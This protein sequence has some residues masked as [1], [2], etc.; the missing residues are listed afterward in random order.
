M[1]YSFWLY[2]LESLTTAVLL[3]TQEP[4]KAANQRV[5]VLLEA[6]LYQLQSWEGRGEVTSGRNL[7]FPITP[8]R[9]TTEKTEVQ[10]GL[11]VR[12]SWLSLV[13]LDYTWFLFSQEV[14]QGLTLAGIYPQ[15][16]LFPWAWCIVRRLLALGRKAPKLIKHQ[17][18]KQCSLQNRNLFSLSPRRSWSGH[19]C[20][21]VIIKSLLA[22]LLEMVT[23]RPLAGGLG[24]QQ[25]NSGLMSVP[26]PGWETDLL[27]AGVCRVSQLLWIL[28]A[29][30][31]ITISC[32][33]FY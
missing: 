10:Q 21:T 23:P 18:G 27:W 31:E 22:S 33:C 26:V 25:A 20:L 30:W 19:K 5:S 17:P 29:A 24:F 6:F 3:W 12:V 8:N 9:L 1:T 32:K 2:S 7:L 15:L 11:H 14:L 4:C 16:R 13:Q 28:P